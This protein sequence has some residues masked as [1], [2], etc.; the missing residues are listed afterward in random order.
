MSSGP[1]HFDL[2]RSTFED[3]LKVARMYYHLDLTT[4][5]IAG[6]LGVS[7]PTISRLLSWAKQHGVVEFRIIDHRS[8]QLSLETRLEEHFGISEVKVVPV[9]AQSSDRQ[10]IVLVGKFAAHYLNTLI[11]LNSV[12]TLAWGATISELAR[13]LIPKP[14]P[15]VQVVQLNGSG[16][17]GSGISYAAGI[18]TAFA[19]NYSAVSHL[20]PIPAYFDNPATKEAILQERAVKRLRELALSADIALYSIGVPDADSYIYRAGYLERRELDALLADDVVGDIATVFFRSDGSTDGLTINER[21][22]GPTLPR[23]AERKHAIC[24]VAGEKKRA[25]IL[26]ALRG[27]FMNTLII[28]EPTA[29]KLLPEA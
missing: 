11:Q 9:P 20:L 5:E 1:V 4:E 3:A 8:H 10:R 14:L 16:N 18:V 25:G 2:E 29:R 6:N 26:G 23:L 19:E 24:I 28:D 13:N 27:R 15:G 21:S 17:S 7:R 22:S 12:L